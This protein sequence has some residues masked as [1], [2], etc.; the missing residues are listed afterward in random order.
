[1]KL[2]DGLSVRVGIDKKWKL[3]HYSAYFCYYDLTTIFDII[4]KPHCTISTNFYFYL[5]YFQ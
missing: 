3:F 1:M 5:Q 4:H 2:H